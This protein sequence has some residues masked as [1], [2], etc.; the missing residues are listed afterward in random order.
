M[1]IALLCSWPFAR[2][3]SQHLLKK[4]LGVIR[5]DFEGRVR[6]T[7]LSL[8]Y[9]LEYLSI[10]S[11]VKWRSSCKH[12]VEDHTEAPDIALSIVV[13]LENFRSDVVRLDC[14]TGHKPF[15]TVPIFSSSWVCLL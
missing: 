5:D 1:L 15:F 12:D 2:I 3:E 7:V 14:Q 6:D 8:L 9:S 4:I 10:V 11:T 13:T